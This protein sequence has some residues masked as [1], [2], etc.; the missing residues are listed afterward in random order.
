MFHGTILDG[1]KT[2]GEEPF[3]EKLQ[4]FFNGYAAA[5]K[6]DNIDLF[7]TLDGMHIKFFHIKYVITGIHFLPVDKNVYL[8]IQSFI[9]LME[10][11]FPN[12][13]FSTFL[14]R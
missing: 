11:T 2:I 8:R 13:Q 14:Y 3:K 12:I 4:S 9:N 6:F 5:M 1:I 10:N 7:S